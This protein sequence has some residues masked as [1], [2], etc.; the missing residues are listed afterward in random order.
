[1]NNWTAVNHAQQCAN[2]LQ[3]AL[4]RL[5]DAR[6][7][8]C[9]PS[10]ISLSVLENTVASI[11][12]HEALADDV[13]SEEVDEGYPNEYTYDEIDEADAAYKSELIECSQTGCDECSERLARLTEKD[14]NR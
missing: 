4:D 10:T 2:N 3:D 7:A 8:G 6:L 14:G 13:S 9:Y 12:M 5:Y 11:V 1:M